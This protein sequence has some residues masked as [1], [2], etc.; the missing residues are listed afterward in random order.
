MLWK[1]ELCVDGKWQGTL[2]KRRQYRS[3][4]LSGWP[5]SHF[6]LQWSVTANWKNWIKF[7]FSEFGTSGPL[8]QE[9]NFRMQFYFLGSE[10]ESTP[11]SSLLFV[12]PEQTMRQKVSELGIQWLVVETIAKNTKNTC[13][14]QYPVSPTTRIANQ[15]PWKAIL[16]TISKLVVMSQGGNLPLVRV[17]TWGKRKGKRKIC[18]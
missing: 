8:V 2:R 7:S 9:S 3:R 17:R 10:S 18:K 13:R 1:A 4:S 14:K 15:C 6:P 12:W 11:I 16:S 5:T